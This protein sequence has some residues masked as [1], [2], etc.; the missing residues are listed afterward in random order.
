MALPLKIP[1]PIQDILKMVPSGLPFEG[2]VDRTLNSVAEKV[3]NSMPT[4]QLEKINK[5]LPYIPEIEV[6]TP[7]GRYHTPEF[8]LPSVKIPQL[9]LR[10]REAFKAAVLKDLSGLVEKIPGVGAVAG[11]MS[12]SLEDT[13]ENKIYQL[14]TPEEFAYYAR[15][16]KAT[17]LST[18]AVIDTLRR[19]F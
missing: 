7:L 8:S 6:S 16:D 19:N 18:M 17:P 5:S 12:D 14:F 11:F 2:Q 9:T 13:G 4:R 15:R 3:S 10:D 1:K